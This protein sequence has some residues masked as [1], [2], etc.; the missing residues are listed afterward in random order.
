M[1]NKLIIL[2]PGYNFAEGVDKILNK[3]YLE[4]KL[5]FKTYIFDNSSKPFIKNISNKYK[6]MGLNVEYKF[7]QPRLSAQHNWSN[8]IS[9]VFNS[10]KKTPIY[11]KF[12]FMLL[13]QD[14]IP[15]DKNFFKKL[16]ND[17]ERN[18]KNIISLNTIVYDKSFFNNRLHTE[19]YLRQFIYKCFP[20]Y[21]FLR[22]YFGP[23]SSFVFKSNLFCFKYPTFNNKLDWLIDVEFYNKYIIN[24]KIYFSNLNIKSYICNTFSITS[25][26]TKKRKLQMEE[27][28]S[29]NR[30]P[31]MRYFILDFLFWYSIRTIQYS[32]YLL[33]KIFKK[34]W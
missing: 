31:R 6:K 17:I 1:I 5:V 34:I 26:L 21:F 19:S 11:S 27:L 23:I 28:K 7:S 22:N 24:Q 10:L 14:D 8:L 18:N 2:I 16:H 9:Y 13:H 30:K 3:I 4:N 32:K 15:E 12:Y 20:K 29:L 25:S 33:L